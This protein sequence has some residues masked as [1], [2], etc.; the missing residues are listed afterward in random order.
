[1]L[2][3][4]TS[5]AGLGGIYADGFIDGLIPFTRWVT[6]P[7]LPKRFTT[8][9]YIYF[10]PLAGTPEASAL[11][12]DEEDGGAANT[13]AL[14]GEVVI[15]PPTHDGGLEHTAARF[16]HAETWLNM[17]RSGEIILFPP[18]FFLLYLVNQFLTTPAADA[19]Q[20]FSREELKAQ[21]KALQEFVKEGDPPWGEKVM[22]PI[23]AM[24]SKDGRS[25]LGLD[26]PGHEL[27]DSGRRGDAERVVLVDFSKEGPRDVEI[28]WRKEV[29]EEERQRQ[30]ETKL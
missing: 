11:T 13:E 26:K 14:S 25:I 12:S 23:V 7:Q 5:R 22:S 6:P 10:L 28:R 24:R 3:R 17:A 2:V 27:K 1:M 15:P 9:M 16:L 4:I 21:R 8:Q 20:P 18:Q 30:G 19:A 29:M